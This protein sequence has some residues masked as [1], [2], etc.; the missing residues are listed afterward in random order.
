MVLGATLKYFG[1]PG[2]EESEM[3][4]LLLTLVY[5]GSDIYWFTWV[6]NLKEKLPEYISKYVFD[7][8][9]GVGG[10]I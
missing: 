7:F 3:V 8:I 1:T 9:M 10:Q 5:L 2:E 6:F 4:L